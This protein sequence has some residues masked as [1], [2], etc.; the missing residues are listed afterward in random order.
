MAA[1]E[2]GDVIGGVLSEG[3]G[4]VGVEV[5]GADHGAL[6]DDRHRQH[7]V[8]A[9]IGDADGEVWEAFVG[10]DHLDVGALAA[11]RSEA[12]AVTTGVLDVVIALNEAFVDAG[13]HQRLPYRLA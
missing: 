5:E 6:V 10:G 13:E 12:W 4:L 7:A 2:A 11:E 1:D 3:A 8:D 9:V